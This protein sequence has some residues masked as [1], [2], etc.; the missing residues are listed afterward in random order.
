M[1]LQSLDMTEYR[2]ENLI[3]FYKQVTSIPERIGA[4]FRAT[5]WSSRAQ[6]GTQ[7]PR[8]SDSKFSIL[9]RKKKIIQWTHHKLDYL[10]DCFSPHNIKFLF[11]V[12]PQIWNLVYPPLWFSPIKSFIHKIISNISHL[13][14]SMN[15]SQYT[16]QSLSSSGIIARLF[17][18]LK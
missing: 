18:L 17:L 7:E 8:T 12:I 5:K 3:Q 11:A 1:G 10:V 2:E 13:Q 15:L 16:F 6:T 4:F 14:F 9:F